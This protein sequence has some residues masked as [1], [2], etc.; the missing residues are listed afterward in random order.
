MEQYSSFAEFVKNF[1]G[2][3]ELQEDLIMSIINAAEHEDYQLVQRLSSL[4]LYCVH[5]DL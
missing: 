1:I 2:K 5:N 4:L 3:K